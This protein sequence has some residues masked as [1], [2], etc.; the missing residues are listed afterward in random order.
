MKIPPLLP[1]LRR[2]LQSLRARAEGYVRGFG[3]QT[4]EVLSGE[5]IDF[6]APSIPYYENLAT[7]LSF[8][9]V[10]LYMV[11]LVF[12]VVTVISNH[13]L[14]TYEN[15]YYLAKDI[16][17]ATQTAQS[18]ADYVSYPISSADADFALY[19]GGV[20]IAG[21]EVV[22]AMSGSGRQTLSVN[23][24][25]ADPC[26]R[27]SDKYC[28]TFGRGERSFAVYNAFVQVHRETTEFP[29]YD[30]TVGDNG[31]FAIVTRSRDY[32][33]E[34]V[35][36]DGN[37][38]RLANYRVNGYVTG[39]S[40][41]PEG[42]R[43]GVVS[44]ESQNNLWVTKVTVIRMENRITEE[45]A[46]VSGALGS[47][48]GFVTDDRFA[49]V[50]SDRLM[51]F[52]TDATVTGEI[53]FEGTTPTLAAIGRGEIAILSGTNGDLTESALTVYDRNARELYRVDVDG[54]HPICQAG[55]PTSLSFGDN[56]LFLRAGDILFRLA[57]N[58]SN[59]T[60]AAISRDTLA[61]LPCDGS[62]VMVCT[63]AYAYRLEDKD[64]ARS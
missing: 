59:V 46:I 6:S 17:A 13:K 54:D 22:T 64:F 34:V 23:V 5:P 14:I 10:V 60:S 57:G 12:V 9:R 37:M 38:E 53:L 11:L 21:S 28:L 25:Y 31:N 8:A 43:L 48:C 39:V 58:G 44:V 18:Q 33:S 3:K 61:V 4:D 32:T 55:T 40:M 26:V 36:Y 49:V 19:R 47:T 20:V 52:K 29:I 50:L 63:P 7:R 16:S 2:A 51:V 30:A 35:I 41:N 27:A 15:L 62:E 1:R 42:D 56:I 45:S 24:E